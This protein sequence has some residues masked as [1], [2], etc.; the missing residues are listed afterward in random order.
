MNS[1]SARPF[2]EAITAAGSLRPWLVM[3]HGASQHRGLFAAQVAFFRDRYRLLLIDLPGHGRSSA[4]PGPYGIGEYTDAVRRALDAAGVTRAHYWG[5]HTGAAVGLVLALAE[6]AR[7]GALVLEGVVIP[8][9]DMPSVVA[10]VQRARR[11]ALTHGMDAARRDW[12]DTAGWFD[13][14]RRRPHD[15]R[16]S[17]HWSIFET[18]AGGPWTDT[19]VPCPVPPMSDRLAEVAAPVLLMN[20]EF[21]LPDFVAVADDLAARLPAATRAVVAGAGGF[22]LWEAPA[23]VNAI[24]ARFLRAH[25]PAAPRPHDR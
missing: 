19:R 14:I 1:A 2:F 21:D 15:C 5:T 20:G 6:P 7:L 4:M 24:V 18:F 11:I 22:P 8:G 17:D 9:R 16:A 23:Q 12:F 25:D 10:A 3:V 13:V